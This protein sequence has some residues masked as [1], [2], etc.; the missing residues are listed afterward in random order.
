MQ[1]TTT[2]AQALVAE[3]ESAIT[4]QGLSPGDPLGTIDE[5]RDRSGYARATV[6]EA[7]RILADR[8][9][10]EVR[11]GRGGGIFVHGTGPVVR[12][13]HTLLATH[14]EATRVADA[15]AIREAL[16][17]LVVRDAARSRKAADLR[18]LRRLL[19]A[20]ERAVDDRDAFM[21]A[22]WALHER[23]AAITPNRMLASVYLSMVGII[24][25]SSA[26][27]S[28]DDDDSTAYSRLRYEVHERLVEA[29]AADDDE[30]VAAA[31]GEHAR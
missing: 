21:R 19:A 20:L 14:G 31:L 8:G 24:R 12:L 9:R 1:S 27:P 4:A 22:N 17:P 30:S 2:R 29:I 25:D 28:G 6:S 5:W 16:E 7:V 15:I 11:P 26:M 23:I 10:L 13:R 3:M 18:E